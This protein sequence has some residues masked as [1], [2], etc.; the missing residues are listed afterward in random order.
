VL[1][2]V[3]EVGSDRIAHRNAEASRLVG[4]QQ[5]RP[6]GQGV[7]PGGRS[8]SLDRHPVSDLVAGVVGA[9]S[10]DDH[11]AGGFGGPPVVDREAVEPIDGQPVAAEG[12]RAHRGVADGI[13]VPVDD[14]RVALDRSLGIGHPRGSKNGVEQGR[15]DAAADLRASA[16][17]AGVDGQ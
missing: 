7:G 5:D 9:A 8:A 14:P 1:P 15:V 13:A 12:R 2:G 11:L 4:R 17:L 6:R 3:D 10:V 16:G